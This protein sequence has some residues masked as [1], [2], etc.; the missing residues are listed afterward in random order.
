LASTKKGVYE[1]IY[2]DTN[3]CKA[4]CCGVNFVEL[5]CRQTSCVEGGD[6]VEARMRD[7]DR[8]AAC[9]NVLGRKKKF[10]AE[11]HFI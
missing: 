10:F 8:S 4:L 9:P 6:A 11:V 3:P 7:D 5:Y 1:E 2:E